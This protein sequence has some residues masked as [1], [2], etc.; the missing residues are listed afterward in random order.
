MNSPGFVEKLHIYVLVY[1]L[2]SSNWELGFRSE[3]REQ[4]SEFQYG[5]VPLHTA[6]NISYKLNFKL[7]FH[8]QTHILIS[9]VFSC[10]TCTS[11]EINVFPPHVTTVD[12]RIRH[13]EAQS[14]SYKSGKLKLKAYDTAYFDSDPIST[15]YRPSI[16]DV[17]T[18]YFLWVRFYISSN[19]R[20]F[21]GFFPLI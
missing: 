14:W 3:R 10:M 2:R 16:T 5:D 17:N 6:Y 19:F 13:N 7:T 11:C 21:C 18:N 9:S 20:C 12:S 8:K 15:K 1:W 4:T